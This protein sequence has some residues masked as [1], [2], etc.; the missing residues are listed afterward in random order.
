[1]ATGNIIACRIG[2]LLMRIR[3]RSGSTHLRRTNHLNLEHILPWPTLLKLK[4]A[5]LVRLASTP[6]PRAP[7][8]PLKAAVTTSSTPKSAS[9]A[10][11]AR[12][13]APAARFPPEPKI[14]QSFFNG[15]W[16]SWLGAVFLFLKWEGVENDAWRL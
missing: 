12:A 14:G 5:P 1:M 7:F 16:P 2:M 9:I 3:A 4:N 6:A 13:A 11:P 15:A 8:L 10:E